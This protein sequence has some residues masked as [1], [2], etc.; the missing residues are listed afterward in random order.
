MTSEQQSWRIEIINRDHVVDAVGDG[1]CDDIADLGI[2]GVEQVRY[3]RLY[4]LHGQL[5]QEDANTVATQLLADPV[6]QDYRCHP[7]GALDSTVGQWG[8]EVWFRP[9]VTDAVGET[10]IKGVRDLGILGIIA[11]ETGRGYIISG[12]VTREQMDIICRR[13]L[14]NDVIE[15]YQYY[16]S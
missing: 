3:V 6:T 8:V 16:T 15:R 12:Q 9:G 5:S 14:A 10:T 4:V 13:L 11:A 7:E 1:L 2:Q